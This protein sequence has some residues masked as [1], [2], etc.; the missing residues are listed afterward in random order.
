MNWVRI[1]LPAPGQTVGLIKLEL[2]G[3]KICLA[4]YAGRWMAIADRCTHNGASLSQGRLTAFGEVVCPL[5]GYRFRLMD[6][7][8]SE[9]CADAEIFPIKEESGEIFISV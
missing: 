5:H 9:A 1:S 7:R 3:K 8:C 6:G 4:H 2:S